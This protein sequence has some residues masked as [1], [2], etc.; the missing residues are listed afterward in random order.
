MHAD[1]TV[2]AVA[3]EVLRRILRGLPGRRNEVIVGM[4]AFAAKISD[5][6]AEVA[7]SIHCIRLENHV[8]KM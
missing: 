2:R 5:E 7:V 8:R 3:A 4:A 6:Y 1:A